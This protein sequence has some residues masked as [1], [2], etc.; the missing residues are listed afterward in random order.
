MLIKRML[1][2]GTARVSYDS[3]NI[4]LSTYKDGVLTILFSNNT[5]YA[6]SGVPENVYNQFELAESQGK[7][8][9]KL[10]KPF[11]YVKLDE[12]MVQNLNQYLDEMNRESFIE[13][14]TEIISYYQH[15]AKEKILEIDK[16]EWLIKKL[17]DYIQT[18]KER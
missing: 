18:K 12:G 13:S 15:F 17:S 10:I 2:E 16:I 7:I 5:A 4:K 9:F 3:S 11:D 8:L 14:D 6:Y 1:V